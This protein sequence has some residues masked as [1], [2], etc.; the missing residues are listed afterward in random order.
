MRCVLPSLLRRTRC[1]WLHACLPLNCGRTPPHNTDTH[2]PPH[3]THPQGFKAIAKKATDK[4]L[5]GL[6]P[7]GLPD[8]PP[9]APAALPAY[10]AEPRRSKV[11]ALVE[12]YVARYA[13][14]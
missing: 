9:A 5:A 2:A 6:P 8:A 13:V 3:G 1:H 11:R 7:P 14:A 10:F 4:V 12:G